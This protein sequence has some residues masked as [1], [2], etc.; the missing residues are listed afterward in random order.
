[1]VDIET[2][3]EGDVLFHK[4]SG[5]LREVTGFIKDFS[6]NRDSAKLGPRRDITYKY[7]ETPGDVPGFHRLEAGEG[8][9]W[10]AFEE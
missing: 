3:S 2:L 10:E 5:A 7:D 4:D 6:G 1:M 9:E 8:S